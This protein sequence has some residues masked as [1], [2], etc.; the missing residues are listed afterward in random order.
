MRAVKY[1]KKCKK[2]FDEKENKCPICKNRL[3][4]KIKPKD[5]EIKDSEAAEIVSA[6]MING[7]L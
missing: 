2:E 4:K 6:M 3:T 7:I 5:C 1:C